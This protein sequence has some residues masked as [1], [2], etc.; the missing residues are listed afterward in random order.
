[1]YDNSSIRKIYSQVFFIIYKLVKIIMKNT[2]CNYIYI[3]RF[4]VII[5]VRKK[6]SNNLKIL[7]IMNINTYEL[8]LV[9]SPEL[10]AEEIDAVISTLGD[11]LKEKKSKLIH[12]D[13]WGIKKLSYPI[14][15]FIEASYTFVIFESPSS[16]IDD[17]KQWIKNNN[18][19]L[20]YLLIKLT[21]S[22]LK[23]RED[24]L[25]NQTAN[26]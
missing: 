15:N 4:H 19:I 5:F 11:L 10:R 7:I 24:N 9:T 18:S 13:K 8:A 23:H 6:L 26:N 3:I 20:R 2:V 12:I 22:E 21:H 25:L 17:I 14:N 16:D 1:M